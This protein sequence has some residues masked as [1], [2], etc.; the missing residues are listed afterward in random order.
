RWPGN[1]REL[2]NALARGVAMGGDVIDLDDLPEAIAQAVARPE[3]AKPALGED[4]RLK[5]AL[6]STEQAYIGAA[7]TRAKGNQTVAARLLG[8]SR[9]GLQKKLRR[10]AGE[11]AEA[12][13][14]AASGANAGGD[15]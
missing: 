13:A 10:L 8:L 11:D 6:V 15:D 14:D 5:P 1:V 4:L 2:E 12:G 3:P 9:F 7:M